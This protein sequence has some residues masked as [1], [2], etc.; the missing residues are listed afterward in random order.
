[1]AKE[2]DIKLFENYSELVTNCSQLKML[3]TDGKKYLSDVAEQLFRNPLNAKKVLR[4]ENSNQQIT[5][6][7]GFETR[8]N[9]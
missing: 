1:M 9:K 5:S 6:K 7:D 2:T 8:P 4:I 3:A